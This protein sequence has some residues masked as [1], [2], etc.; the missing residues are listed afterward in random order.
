[1]DQISMFSLQEHPAN[2]SQSQDSEEEW[3]MTAATSRSNFLDW[4]NE[5]APAGFFGRMSLGYSA[6][7]KDGTLEPSLGVWE[8]SGMGMHTQCLTLNISSWRN[9][10]DVC[11]LSD[12]LEHGNPPQRYYLTKRACEGILRRAENRGSILPES[13]QRALESTSAMDRTVEP[14]MSEMSAPQS[15]QSTEPGEETSQS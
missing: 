4:L 9:G 8:K 11:L 2:P 14:R 12:T 10:A 1:M 3:M 5:R 7:T 13:L 15:P 6:V